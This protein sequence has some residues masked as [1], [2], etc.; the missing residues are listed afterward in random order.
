MNINDKCPTNGCAL[1]GFGVNMVWCPQCENPDQ[2]N[3]VPV[4]DEHKG[5]Y[6]HIVVASEFVHNFKQG[7]NTTFMSKIHE[8]EDLAKIAA[9]VACASSPDKDFYIVTVTPIRE[10]ADKFTYDAG[11]MA[12]ITNDA[13]DYSGAKLNDKLILV[14]MQMYYTFDP[15]NP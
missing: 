12:C 6:A 14:E 3:N 11:I 1:A 13:R 15:D 5:N 8:T 7:V 9:S 2:R 4:I 10:L